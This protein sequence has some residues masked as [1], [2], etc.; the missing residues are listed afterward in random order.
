[1]KRRDFFKVA[2]VSTTMLMT[3]GCL[4]KKLKVSDPFV[5]SEV[6]GVE[7]AKMP[8]FTLWQLPNQ[9]HSQINSYVI[10][11]ADNEII[12]MDGGRKGDAGYLSKFIR[13][14]DNHV[15]AWFIS[16]PHLDHVDALTAILNN[17]EGI[18]IDAIYA[19]LPDDNWLKKHQNANAFKTQM[20]LKAALKTSGHEV[21]DLSLGQKI[22][23]QG[24]TF[25]ILAVRNPEL[26]VNAVN[27]QSVVW[28]VDGGGK[29]V[30]FL[31]DLGVEGGEKLLSSSYRS[32]L[33]ADYVQMAHH[34]QTGVSEDFYNTVNPKF[35]LWPTP[36]WLWEN[37]SGKGRNSG[38][39]KTLEVRAW[40]KKLNIEKHYTAADGLHRIDFFPTQ[41]ANSPLKRKPH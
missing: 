38:P 16:H 21:L 7:N 8:A 26:T 24:A 30:L 39:W 9:T 10:R 34:G 14:R 18:T 17:S 4:E 12:V 37:D 1:M 19:S 25:E 36:G 2:A 29:S 35:C 33:K 6:S 3:P 15:H 41:Q 31:G 11:T 5:I 32:R 27:N 13:D 23:F 40:M 20:D 28:R 22:R